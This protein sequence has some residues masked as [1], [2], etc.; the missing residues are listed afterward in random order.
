MSAT[1]P[2][3]VLHATPSVDTYI[4]LRTAAGLSPKTAM[5]AIRGLG[6]TLYAV[7][8]LHQCTPV[9]MGRVVGDGGCFYQV[10]DI[11]VRPEFQG[12][13][14]GK[15][16]MEN[17]MAYL[18]DNVPPSGYVSLIADGK[19]HELYA[20]YGFAHTAPASVGMALTVQ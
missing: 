3:D 8:I 14:L 19:A 6:N 4:Q 11:A 15:R 20:K 12:Q 13:G 5:A 7:Q 18:R 2:F 1:S 10:V 9:A 17:I 16:V